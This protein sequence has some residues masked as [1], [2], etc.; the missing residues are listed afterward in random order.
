MQVYGSDLVCLVDKTTKFVQIIFDYVA[1][2]S[3]LGLGKAF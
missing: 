3:V 1:F 2:G